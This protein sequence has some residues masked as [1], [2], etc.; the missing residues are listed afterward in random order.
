L[1]YTKKRILENNNIR[2]P[3][4]PPRI[5]EIEEAIKKL[6]KNKAP[7]EDGIPAE[8]LQAK[9]RLSAEI[10]HRPIN[11]IW[12]EERVPESWKKGI[13][14]KLPKKGDPTDCNNWRGITLLNTIYK[15]IA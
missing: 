1:N 3:C 6:K 7:G 2:I 8:L 13:I 4:N 14:I 10:L 15:L 12:E 11:T 9:S 5:S